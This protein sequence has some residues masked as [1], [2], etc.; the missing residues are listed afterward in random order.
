[1][2]TIFGLDKPVFGAAAAGV[3]VLGLGLGF[4]ISGG[5]GAD[6]GQ[7]PSNARPAVE[8]EENVADVTEVDGAT[9]TAPTPTQAPREVRVQ[10]L[11]GSGLGGRAGAATEELK[12]SGYDTLKALDLDDSPVPATAIY[13][14]A[15]YEGA[16]TSIATDLGFPT[17]VRPMP[18]TPPPPAPAEANVVVVLGQDIDAPASDTT[19]GGSG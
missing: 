9:T 15:G 13:F 12:T 4:A 1:M 18:P 17:A 3:A 2:S 11:N 16:A 7:A 14:Q 5:L 19:T 10:V 8:R 6:E